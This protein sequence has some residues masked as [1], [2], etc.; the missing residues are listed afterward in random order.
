VLLVGR[1]QALGRGRRSLV[2]REE[3]EEEEEEK[4]T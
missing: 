3:E 4:E 2:G 1:R